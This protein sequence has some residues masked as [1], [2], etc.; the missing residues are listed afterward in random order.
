MDVKD[1]RDTEKG[2]GN[3]ASS[4]ERV[5]HIYYFST[6]FARADKAKSAHLEG[7]ARSQGPLGPR[8]NDRA[9][10]IGHLS[11]VQRCITTRTS[12]V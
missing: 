2:A 11:V 7:I 3:Q 8:F 10:K 12:S 9:G 5:I 1:D 4:G 6:P